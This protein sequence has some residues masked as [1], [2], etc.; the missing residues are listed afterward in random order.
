MQPSLKP[1]LTPF[2]G[3]PAPDAAATL[4]AIPLTL[5]TGVDP[6]AKAACLQQVLAARPVGERWAVLLNSQD[7]GAL[8][9]LGADAQLQVV[10]L[11]GGCVCC[12]AQ[13]AL[14]V[15]LRKLLKDRPQR[16]VLELSAVGR[17]ADAVDAIRKG[18]G[19]AVQVQ[20]IIAAVGA[21]QALPG[22]LH[23][24]AQ[25]VAA[26]MLRSADVWALADDLDAEPWRAAAEQLWPSPRCVRIAELALIAGR[27]PG[28]GFEPDG[29]PEDEP[30]A[31]ALSAARWPGRTVF[32]RQALLAALPH[33]QPSAA[34]LS[35]QGV[36]QTARAWYH[37]QWAD[38][39]WRWTE[40][41]WRL[42]SRWQRLG[43]EAS[44]ADRSQKQRLEIVAVQGIDACASVKAFNKPV[45]RP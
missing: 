17:P 12:V 41:D 29:E 19:A 3:L 4:A 25:S 45:S 34:P 15:Q 28:A 38:Q 21:G 42:D 31:N 10:A 43:R 14:L 1:S 9:A 11:A 18:L 20:A 32:D 7:A 5:I 30:G 27:E 37:V 26:R 13:V 16:F 36:F 2:A 23:D 33:W 8:P 35:A 39:Q 22:G 44:P 24:G 40:S 6:A